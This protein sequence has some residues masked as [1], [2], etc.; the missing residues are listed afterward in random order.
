MQIAVIGGGRWARAL[1]A[2]LSNNPDRVGRVLQIARRDVPAAEAQA[3]GVEFSDDMRGL[4]EV[5]VV[6]L[7]VTAAAARRLLHQAGAYLHGGQYAV[8]AI[9]SLEPTEGAG[10]AVRI[11]E[12]IHAETAV[13]R[14]GA[15]AG[16][17]LAQDLEEGRP[18][19]LI[20]GSRFDEVGQALSQAL[21][22]SSLRVYATRD[23]LGVELA[24]AMVAEV[25]LAAGVARALEMGPAARA[26]LI[27]RGAAEM[28]RLGVAM[29]A[30]ERTFFGLAGVGEMVVATEG[31]GSADFELGVAL[32]RGLGLAEALR[33][34]GR[35]C[36]G[37]TMVREAHRLGQKYGVRMTLTGALQ[38]WL[39]GERSMQQG[40]RDLFAG[41]ERGE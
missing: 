32:G 23:L 10:E 16:P 11:S 37:P 40:L 25:A 27:A 20:C 5:D 17:A 29:G 24:R 30:S 8:H 13:R 35:H 4:A 22:S 6:V 41:D 18:A 14:I 33:K 36:D 12:V 19:A 28:A 2:R 9:G 21:S 39:G 1:G 34:I 15:L 7:A 31:R 26:I 3:P 38:R